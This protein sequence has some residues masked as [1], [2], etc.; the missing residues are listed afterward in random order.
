MLR[1]KAKIFQDA[2]CYGITINNS[3]VVSKYICK[4]C[5]IY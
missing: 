3:E 5:N 1:D 2:G 4:I